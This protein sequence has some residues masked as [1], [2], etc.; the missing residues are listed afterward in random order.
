MVAIIALLDEYFDLRECQDSSILS[1]ELG[2]VNNMIVVRPYCLLDYA[3]LPSGTGP[4]WLP[5]PLVTP[6]QSL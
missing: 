3:T 2:A 4:C 6:L 5:E 1:P